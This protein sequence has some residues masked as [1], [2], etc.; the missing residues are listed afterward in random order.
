VTARY[1]IAFPVSGL[2]LAAH[3]EL[4]SELPELGYAD[5]WTGEASGYDGITPLALAAAWA[6]ALGLGTAVL[7]VQTRGPAL[8]AMT[9]ATLAA[10]TSGRIVLGIGSSGRPFVTDINGIP[11]DRPYQRLR[12]AVR[13]LR[14]V[15]A[16]EPASGDFGSFSIRAFQLAVPSPRPRI[17]VGALRPGMLR[18][19]VT[20]ADG[21]I[22]NLVSSGDVAKILAELGTLPVGTEIAARIHVCLTTDRRTARTIGRQFLGPM[23]AASTYSAAHQWLGR[24]TEI[25][26]IRH[27]ASAGNLRGASSAVSD[28]TVDELIVH[29]SPEECRQRIA[30]FLRAGLTTPILVPLPSP[31]IGA[32]VAGYRRF[33]HAFRLDT[34][35][36]GNPS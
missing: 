32:G 36:Q 25:T 15:L 34:E 6:P 26:A 18:L 27:A 30:E 3:R 29:G 35:K 17:L 16:G 13:F 2:P 21:V 14:M 11:F 10:A 9:A 22:M 5:V 24:T 1:G 31:E 20:E 7:P 12:D 28:D 23:L 19:G 8:L 33:T 4:I